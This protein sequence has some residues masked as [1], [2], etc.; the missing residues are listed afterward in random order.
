M[1]ISYGLCWN[2]DS[3]KIIWPPRAHFGSENKSL[4]GLEL[5]LV[6]HASPRETLL[7][8]GGPPV[9][10]AAKWRHVFNLPYRR[11]NIVMSALY[12]LS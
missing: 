8:E 11:S 5:Y 2:I 1:T 6:E 9:T 4:K 12:V 3:R 7:R 10:N